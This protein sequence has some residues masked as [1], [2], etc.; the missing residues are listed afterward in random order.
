[1]LLL[2]MFLFM[3]LV[4]DVFVMVVMVI[5]CVVLGIFAYTCEVFEGLSGLK[6]FLATIFLPVTM[7]IG[8]GL[9]FR[10]VYCDVVPTMLWENYEMLRDSSNAIYHL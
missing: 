5:V 7:M 1:M 3:F 4:R 2:L 6:C 9:A 10:E 8:V